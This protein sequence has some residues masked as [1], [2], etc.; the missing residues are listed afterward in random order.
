MSEANVPTQQTQTSP[1]ARLP[2]PDV[3]QGGARHLEGPPPEGAAPAVGLIWRVDRRT[4]LIALQQARR[5]RHGPLAVSWVAGDPA[6]PPRVAF[7]IGRRVGSAVVR[8]RLRRQLR[9]VVRETASRLPP[10]AYMIGVGPDASSLDY[11][12]LRTHLM[13]A[14]DHLGE[15][16]ECSRGH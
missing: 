5:H 6:E 16:G 2:P 1:Q 9:M 10:G 4:T 11:E 7:A 8:N 15:S 13:Q 12:E 14:L 3:D